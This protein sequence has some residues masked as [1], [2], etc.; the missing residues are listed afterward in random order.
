MKFQWF[1]N[2]ISINGSLSGVL[3]ERKVSHH[4]A[5]VYGAVSWIVALCIRVYIIG[6][7]CLYFKISV[8][9][10]FYSRGIYVWDV[11]MIFLVWKEGFFSSD[12]I[13]TISQ[14]E[15]FASSC[16]RFF[17]FRRVHIHYVGEISLKKKDFLSPGVRESFYSGRVPTPGVEGLFRKKRAFFYQVLWDPSILAAFTHTR[18]GGLSLERKRLPFTRCEGILLF[19]Q[20]SPTPGVEGNFGK[21]KTFFHQVWGNPFILTESPH[22]VWKNLFGKKRTSFHQ[23]WGNPSILAESHTRCGGSL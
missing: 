16:M 3:A 8:K 11:W 17:Y 21:K 22:Q 5:K 2:E 19:W 12:V 20:R 4:Y 7:E 23:V 1:L 6:E 15:V 9:I 18:C 13:R 14:E 10:S